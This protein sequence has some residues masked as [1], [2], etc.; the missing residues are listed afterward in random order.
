MFC[1]TSFFIRHFGWV[2]K[3]KRRLGASLALWAVCVC[4]AQAGWAQESGF[5]FHA[6]SAETP[7]VKTALTDGYTTFFG[8]SP[9]PEARRPFD[10]NLADTAGALLPDG[11]HLGIGYRFVTTTGRLHFASAANVAWGARSF[12]LPEGFGVFKDP[13]RVRLRYRQL[14]LTQEVSAVLFE[15]SLFELD[16][17]GGVGAYLTQYDSSITS[18]LLDINTSG[19]DV[20]GFA[21]IFMT[22]RI[23]QSTP[24]NPELRL[25]AT[26][27]ENNLYDLSVA[28]R[29]QF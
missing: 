5:H 25:Q 19:E 28:A 11:Q 17:G 21:R 26:K 20:T 16:G 29:F 6:G 22:V 24:G 4:V 27:Y 23:G 18:A 13:A 1:N 10:L 3:K 14:S 2:Q 15:R 8:E 9:D 7:F 12:D